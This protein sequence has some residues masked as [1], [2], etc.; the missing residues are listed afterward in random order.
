MRIYLIVFIGAGSKCEGHPLVGVACGWRLC[1]E[2]QSTSDGK[3]CDGDGRPRPC[4]APQCLMSSPL[5][6]DGVV[7]ERG[8]VATDGAAV[9]GSTAC[10]PGSVFVST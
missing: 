2:G 7:H 3:E 10:S 9:C 4:H 5:A 6:G 1:V 8:S